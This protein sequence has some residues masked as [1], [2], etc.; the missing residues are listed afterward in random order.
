[1]RDKPRV[2]RQQYWRAQLTRI[3]VLLVIWAIAG[4]GM[5]ILF[6]EPL[7]NINFFGMPFGFWMAQQGSIYVFVILIFVFAFTA[8]RAD[9][10]AGLD[11]TPET[12]TGPSAAH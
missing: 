10:E 8:G 4:I 2:T 12:T 7:N 9:R 3:T 5:G 1:M 11:E 6:V